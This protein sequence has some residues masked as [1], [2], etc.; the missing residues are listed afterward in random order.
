MLAGGRIPDANGI[1][2]ARR[3][4]QVLAAGYDALN[5]A[6]VGLVVGGQFLAGGEIPNLRAG[7]Q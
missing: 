5:F 3:H 2:V 4:R 6:A 7:D 1:L